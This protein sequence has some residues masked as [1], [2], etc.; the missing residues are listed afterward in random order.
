MRVGFSFSPGGL[1]LPYHVGVLDGLKHKG[2]LDDTVPIAGAS[3]GAIAVATA[4]CQMDSKLL[5]EDTI[6]ISDQCRTLGRARGNLLPLLRQ[7]LEHRIDDD[8]FRAL[9]ERPGK[10]VVSY[11][12]V[13]PAFGPVHQADFEHKQEF[14]DTVCHSSTFPFF[15]SNW[16]VALDYS[17]SSS[18]KTTLWGKPFSLEIPRLVVDGFFAVPGDRFGCPDFELAGIDV[19]RTVAVTSFPRQVIGLSPSL[20]APQDYIGPELIGDGIQQSADLLRMATQ[21]LTPQEVFQLY[22]D[23]FQDAEQW[24]AREEMAI[25]KIEDQKREEARRLLN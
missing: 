9:Q 2:F 20:I 12:E 13:F 1:L 16:P 14:I 23:G 7:K 21:P 19:N 4:A 3:A 18:W 15:S 11:H 25:R 10:A 5:L 6:D 17:T 8:R 22:E 24:S